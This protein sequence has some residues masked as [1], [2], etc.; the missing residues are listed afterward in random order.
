M[1]DKLYIELQEIDKQI[2]E[3]EASVNA[4]TEE[5]EMFDYAMECFHEMMENVLEISEPEPEEITEEEPY[6]ESD[7]DEETDEDDENESTLPFGSGKYRGYFTV[8]C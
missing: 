7:S 5:S 4:S 3:L 2:A 6:E 1:Q 8:V